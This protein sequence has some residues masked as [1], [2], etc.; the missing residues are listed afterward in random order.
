M[1]EFAARSDARDAAMRAATPVLKREWSGCAV[2]QAIADESDAVELWEATKLIRR[3][4][5]A[6]LAAIGAPSERARIAAFAIAPTEDPTQPEARMQPSEPRT[7]E[8]AAASACAAWESLRD[9][10]LGLGPMTVRFTID[11]ICAEV[12]GA[13]GYPVPKAPVLAILRHV[14]EKLVR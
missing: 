9:V 12:P 7:P 10:L 14:H 3:V 1:E 5:A 11:R 6:Y 8:E 2:G 4:R 13:D